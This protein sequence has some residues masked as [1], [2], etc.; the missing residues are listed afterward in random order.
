MFH[1]PQ[2]QLQRLG[3]SRAP[4]PLP[5]ALQLHAYHD[6][7]AAPPPRLFTDLEI[8]VGRSADSRIFAPSGAQRAPTVVRP[9]DL[10]RRSPRALPPL[11]IDAGGTEAVRAR[12]ARCELRE[13]A[14]LAGTPSSGPGGR[15]EE[16]RLFRAEGDGRSARFMYGGCATPEGCRLRL[17]RLTIE[18]AL[19]AEVEP[20]GWLAVRA[21]AVRRCDRLRFAARTR[22]CFRR[23]R[24][25]TSSAGAAAIAA[26]AGSRAPSPG[27]PRRFVR[28]TR[29]R[30]RPART[31]ARGDP[32][33]AERRAR[34]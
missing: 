27:R 10:K 9:P 25:S 12:L 3:R 22:P 21:G 23:G 32:R 5:R 2:I 29:V 14:E 31:H 4:E 1:G 16:L 20:A 18:G 11:A 6:R 19:V 30:S 17:P 13:P 26:G 24:S 34:S 15:F 33:G 8:Y 28:S 7:F